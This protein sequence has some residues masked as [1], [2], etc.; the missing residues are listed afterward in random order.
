MYLERSVTAQLIPPIFAEV[1]ILS[2]Q[3]PAL[4]AEWVVRKNRPRPSPFRQ[5]SLPATFPPRVRHA[6]C[7]VSDSLMGPR[8]LDQPASDFLAAYLPS[9]PCMSSGIRRRFSELLG[10]RDVGLNKLVNRHYWGGPLSDIAGSPAS[11]PL[12][13][14]PG[15]NNQPS[16]CQKIRLILSPSGN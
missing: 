5:V 3:T 12:M 2:W 6:S 9:W 15:P 10:E 11:L 7:E 4:L 16:N 8:F 14:P 13:G 1:I